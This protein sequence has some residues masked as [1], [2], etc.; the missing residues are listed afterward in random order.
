MTTIKIGGSGRIRI[1]KSFRTVVFKT[2]A[3]PV[4]LHFQNILETVLGVAPKNLPFAEVVPSLGYTVL[5]FMPELGVAPRTS[6]L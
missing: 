1:P 6:T 2:T 4:R 5:I 3:L